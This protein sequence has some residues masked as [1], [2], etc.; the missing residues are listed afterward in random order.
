MINPVVVANW[1]M[2]KTAA[3]GEALLAAYLR[4]LKEAGGGAAD[5]RV[6][7]IVAPSFPFLPA[8]AR[9]LA[10]TG[11][12]LGAQDCHWSDEGPFTGEVSAKMLAEVGCKY[13]ILGHSERRE[14]FGETNRRINKKATTALFWRL[15]PI[16]C[17]G[18]KADE[19]ASG[20]AEMVVE[21]QLKRCL[22]NLR[23]DEDQR[24]MIAYEPV[25]AIGT[26]H[27]PTPEEVHS[28]HHVIRNELKTTY[29]EARAAAFPILYGGSVNP[30]T[31]GPML[32]LDV[33]DGVLVGGA[34]LNAEEFVAIV[35]Q[36][37]MAGAQLG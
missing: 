11:L 21:R 8:A 10:N 6:E 34:S 22:E 24:L 31:V 17:I 35:T 1:K 5:P 33:V 37:R 32:D 26:G 29:G 14:H 15:T 16:L 36:A 28:V 23:L 25:W 27:T 30:R 18:E 7:L 4:R 2:Q 9:L 19:R 20:R 12:L 13:V 3:E